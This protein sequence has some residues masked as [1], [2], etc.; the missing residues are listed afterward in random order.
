MRFVYIIGTLFLSYSLL[1]QVADSKALFFHFS[2]GIQIPAGDLKQSFGTN[3]LLTGRAEF[4]INAKTYVGLNSS[5]FFG[6]DVKNDVLANLRT[7]T[8]EIIGTNYVPAVIY[9]R[10]RGS[11]FG[12]YGGYL[13]PIRTTPSLHGIRVNLGAGLLEHHI[14][15]VDDTKSVV[16]VDNDYLK[17]YDHKTYGPGLDLFVGYQFMGSERMLNIFGGIQILAG[18]TK[19]RRSYNFDTGSE[20]NNQRKDILA[21]IILGVSLPIYYGESEILY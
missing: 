14:R 6:N 19:N 9:L 10:E 3:Y 15:I 18:L 1:G 11:F 17:G 4:K 8:G 16:Q 20:I 5:L 12:L 21:G 7:E 2:Y 13:F